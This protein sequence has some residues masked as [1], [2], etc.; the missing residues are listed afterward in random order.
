MRSKLLFPFFLVISLLIYTTSSQVQAQTG[1]IR[2]FVY[3]TE[4]GEP[5]IFTNVY[6]YKTSLGAATDVNGFFS[7]MKIPPGQYTLMVSYMGF[8]TLQIPITIKSNDLITKKLYLKKSTYT[9]GEISISAAREDK[10]VETQTSI[11]KIS[12]KDIGQIPTIGGQPDLAQYLQVLPG[13][14]FSGDQGGQL[15]IRGGPPIQ[16]KV[17][18]DG[19]ELYQPFHSIGLFSVFDVDI[20]K[21]VDVMTGGFGAEYGGRISSIMNITTR[22]GNKNRIAGK[23]DAS[24]FGAK[25]LLE[26]PIA[27]AK[28]EDASGASFILSVKNSYLKES[29]K[30]LYNYIDKNGLPYNYLDIYGKISI[31]AANG[32]KINLYGFD[33][34]DNV[35]YKVLQNYQ[36]DSYGG[37][38]NFIVIPGGSPVL[39]EGNFAYSQYKVT[40]KQ[41]NN[42]PRSSSI[43]GFS[44]GFHF[45]YFFGKDALKYGIDLSGYKTNL[46]FFNSVHRSII[47]DQNT[48]DPSVYVKYKWLMGKFIFEPGLRLQYYASLGAA[49]FEPRL[50]I[51]YNVS[52]RFRL[53][54][55]A[56][57][58]SQNL[59]STTYDKDVVNLFYG[60][61]GGP[62][63]LPDEFNGHK[64]T[65]KYQKSDQVV[66]GFETDLSKNLSLNVEGY[67][68]YYPQLTTL[69]RNKLYEDIPENADKPDYLKKDFVIESGDAEGVDVSLRYDYKHLHFWGVYSLCFIHRYDGQT[70][71]VPVYDRTHNVNLT[72]SYVFGKH[73]GWEADV[74]WN[75]GSGFP[76]TQTAGFYEQINFND[77]GTSVINQNGTLGIIYS[78]YNKGRLPYYSRLD[79]NLKKKFDLGRYT[80]F[81]ISASIT[82]ALNQQNIFY[83]DRVSYKRIDQLP[84]M[85]SMG[86]SFTF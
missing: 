19:M 64:V 7:I 70:W 79:V 59:V 30:I 2:G 14:I 78:D 49:S 42:S 52:E 23:I 62:N 31:N 15:Y 53:K 54:M 38:T 74:R 71:Y 47:L 28:G 77:I 37:G 33:F 25:V 45:T 4:S 76:F 48:T 58:Y 13:V 35:Q 86:M 50:A 5:V 3:E 55:A 32:S 61:I 68:K 40:L 43:S 81:E 65:S 57:L 72:A 44:G 1:V 80:K 34:T 82:N 66:F 73:Q 21:N 11:I 75:Y 9:L 51:K 84:L 16:N 22:D 39:L 24:T 17:L 67:Y 6:L 83:F 20:L 18:L 85:P 60:F 8:D 41:E 46:T 63:N 36:W 69:N 12:P 26:G 56:G 29:S 27:K 10:K